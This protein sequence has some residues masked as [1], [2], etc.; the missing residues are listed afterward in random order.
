MVKVP[1]VPQLT[2]PSSMAWA[3]LKP[4]K[5]ITSIISE[6]ASALNFF[7]WGAYGLWAIKDV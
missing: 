6:S 2:V 1:L 3:G 7:I 4:T 5:L